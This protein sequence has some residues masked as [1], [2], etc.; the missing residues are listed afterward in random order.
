M[1]KK[2]VLSFILVALAS[3]VQAQ[4]N[5]LSPPEIER[6]K[7]F[8]SLIV[9][10]DKKTLAKTVLEIERT[11]DPQMILQI[12]ETIAK[13]YADIVVDQAIKDQQTK[14]WLYSTVAM[15]MANIQ[16]GG[17]VG[18]DPVNQMITQRLRKGLPEG[19]TSRPGFH[20]SVE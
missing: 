4:P 6:V 7:A 11:N 2:L 1:F 18:R 9:E 16:F 17:R 12:Q 19:I 15:N 3:T 5:K 8:K 14:E 20:V 13:V 10:V